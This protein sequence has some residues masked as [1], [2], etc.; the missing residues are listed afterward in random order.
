VD[1]PTGNGHV[2]LFSI[3]PVYRGE[4][5][6]TYSLV[7]ST[8]FLISTA[9]MSVAS[10]RRNKTALVAPASCWRFFRRC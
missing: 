2:V 6:G 4:T 9:S 10:W 3:N 1:V 5:H 8:P 7:L